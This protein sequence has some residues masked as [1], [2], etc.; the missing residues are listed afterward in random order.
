MICWLSTRF[1]EF[2][3]FFTYQ[4]GEGLKC[5][6]IKNEVGLAY[7]ETSVSINTAAM[8]E[9]RPKEFMFICHTSREI[10]S[11]D[12]IINNNYIVNVQ[13]ET[14]RES[15]VRF[16]KAMHHELHIH[17]YRFGDHCM[18]RTI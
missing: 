2:F 14:I 11:S 13:D 3:E 12:G 1:S 10:G 16:E 9:T 17:Q 15:K 7:G 5:Y 8:W 18:V 4:M 6:K